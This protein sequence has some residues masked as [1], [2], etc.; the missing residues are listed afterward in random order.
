MDVRFKHPFTCIVSGPTRA[1][2]SVFTFRLI[3]EANEQI[4][5]PPQQIVYCYGVY[6]SVFSKYPNVKFN[7]GLPDNNDFDGKKRTLLIIDDLM[8]EAGEGVEQIFTKLSHHRDI[9]V[10]FLTQNLFFQSKQFR[11]I[12][13]NTQYLIVFK[14]PR[15]ASQIATL[16]KQMYPNG[17]KFLVDAFRQATDKPHGYLLID[18]QADTL[19]KYR[20]RTNIFDGECQYVFIPK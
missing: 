16:G 1:G 5:P 15:D 7:E 10:I 8:K 6:Q 2:K 19:E 14:N 13:L 4:T 17:K 12:S 18:L 20:I 9:S 3:D 11:T